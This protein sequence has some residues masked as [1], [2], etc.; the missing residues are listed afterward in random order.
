M[1]IRKSLLA[2]IFACSFFTAT[3]QEPVHPA[4]FVIPAL[5]EW[6]GASGTFVLKERLSIVIDPKYS[7]ELTTVA[8]TFAKDLKILLPE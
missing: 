2:A 6:Q 5:R 7:T 4:P 3:A 1:R 8:T